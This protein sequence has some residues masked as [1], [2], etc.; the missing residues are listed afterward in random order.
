M[1]RLIALWVLL[2]PLLAAA[3]LPDFTD[4]VD[5]QGPAVVN[6]STTQT[7][8]GGMP[9][10][11]N[12]PEDDPMFEFFKRFMPP[13]A[14][15][16]EQQTRSEGSGFFISGDGYI[17]TNAHV[18]D[19]AEEITVKLNDKRELKAKVIGF[20]KRTDVAL[21]KVDAQNV[22]KVNMGDPNKLRVGEWVVAIGS[23]FGFENSVT[24]GI[25]S[26]KGRSLP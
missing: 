14:P 16:R 11:P 2:F 18:V 12:I 8:K 3:Q 9:G 10:M 7:S 19:S 25:V 26:A 4:L 13:N 15:P 1:R 20:D 24:A 17:L 23:P 5:K 22:P 6:V 21:I